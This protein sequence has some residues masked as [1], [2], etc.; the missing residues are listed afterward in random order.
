V[1]GTDALAETVRERVPVPPPP[2]PAPD[3]L[4]TQAV[5]H[6][7]AASVDVAGTLPESTLPAWL[8]P[9]LPEL[10]ERCRALGAH[11]GPEQL[12]HW[13]VRDDNVLVREDGSLVFVDWG[14][15]S[16]GPAWADP[17]LARLERVTEPWFD[18]SVRTSPP[19]AALGDEHVTTFLLAFATFLAHRALVA[20]DLNL[21]TMKDFRRTQAARCFAAAARRL[22]VG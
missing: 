4:D 13:D 14:A 8:G 5:L 20:D 19:L 17:L 18:A 12:V 1:R 22:G 11:A 2:R 6:R 7:W 3:L 21:P 9:W 16:R 15:A 10:P